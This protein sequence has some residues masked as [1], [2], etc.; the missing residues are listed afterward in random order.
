MSF[1]SR[2]VHSLAGKML[3]TILAVHVLLIPLIFISWIGVIRDNYE[4]HFVDQVRSDAQW[5]ATFLR[6]IAD[7]PDVGELTDDLVL[8]GF[9]QSIQ[10]YDLDHDLVVNAGHLPM[11]P[12]DPA[13][14]DFFFG[15]HNDSLYWIS[16]PLY[17][18]SNTLSGSLQL[19]YDETPVSNE[20]HALYRRGITFG[21]IYLLLVFIS[22]SI[23][24]NRL[25]RALRQVRNAAHRVAG[26]DYHMRFDTDDT[27]MEIIS[28]SEDLERMRSELVQRGH[29]LQEREMRIR[30]VVDNVAD[31]VLTL[32]EGGRVIT[33]NP[34]AFNIFSARDRQLIGMNFTDC[35]VDIHGGHDLERL[36]GQGPVESLASNGEQRF[37]PVELTL[38]KLQQQQ[39]DLYLVVVRDISQRK[40]IEKEHQ[41]QHDELTHEHRLSSLG[42][43]AAGLAHELNQPLAAINLYMQGCLKR[44]DENPEQLDEIRTA[45][46]SASR[47]AQ[48]AGDIVSQIRGFVRKAPLN[49]QPV[50]LNQLIH[51]TMHLF[52]ADPTMQNTYL[53]LEL[54]ADLPQRQVDGLQIQQVLVNLVSNANNAMA[55]ADTPDR[56]ITISTGY[57]DEC[58][59]VSVTDR[60]QGIPDDIAEQL[61][62]PFVTRRKNGL[63]LG[64]SISR[65]IIEEHGGVLCHHPRPAGGTV[66]SFALP[67][68]S[69]N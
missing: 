16:V 10:V 59:T 2:W 67:Q 32:D 24:S 62:D 6:D 20:I 68:D 37:L 47:Q 50:D 39:Q 4:D 66:F 15:Q 21:S 51:D 57:E 34:A 53:E 35:L 8:S 42:E 7:R 13:R 38:S 41:R 43:M 23:L 69:G 28:L 55:H 22:V 17:N 48:R 64:L 56:R 26:G 45:M 18:S 14:E 12:F 3:L 33:A 46:E 5:L 29:K 27:T 58:V 40:R 30:A 52:D 61:F 9:R 63:G 31:G 44:L 19:A 1:F 60:G 11:L 65:S 54:A 36:S 25:G 49:R